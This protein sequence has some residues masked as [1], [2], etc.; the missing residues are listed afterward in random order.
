MD[1]LVE[2]IRKYNRKREEGEGG[3]IDLKEQKAN[4][5]L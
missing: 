3:V 2:I 1:C 5:F 4:P